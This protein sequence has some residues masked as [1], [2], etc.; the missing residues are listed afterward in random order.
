MK[1]R[2][3]IAATIAA[4]LALAATASA[5]TAARIRAHVPF[6]FYVGED[7]LPAGNYVFEL[8]SVGPASSSSSAIAVYTQDGIMASMISTIPTGWD[9]RYTSDC[10]LHFTRITDHYFLAKLEAP[11]TGADLNLSRIERELRAQ[12]LERQDTVLLAQR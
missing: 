6:E 8:R 4:L 5:S 11:E 10:H 7:K 2:I 3:V 1:S 12:K 9:Y